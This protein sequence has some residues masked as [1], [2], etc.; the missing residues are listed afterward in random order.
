M[1]P[2]QAEQLDAAIT[3]LNNLIGALDDDYLDWR[4]CASLDDWV[5]RVQ[6]AEAV[7]RGWLNYWD[8]MAVKADDHFTLLSETDEECENC[9]DDDGT[10]YPEYDDTIL[11]LNCA[12]SIDDEVDENHRDEHQE[13]FFSK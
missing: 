2:K 5:H 3:K 12:N 4:E 11:C 7:C 13:D 10:N 9:G 8:E 1:T 6:Q